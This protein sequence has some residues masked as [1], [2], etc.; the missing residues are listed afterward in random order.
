MLSSIVISEFAVATNSDLLDA[1]GGVFV[2]LRIV[3]DCL[4][5]V[6]VEI[7]FARAAFDNDFTATV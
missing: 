7:D 4:K 2:S 6:V 5:D 1:K 3:F